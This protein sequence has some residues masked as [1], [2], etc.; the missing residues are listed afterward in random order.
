MAVRT[1]SIAFG[2]KRKE[3]SIIDGERA[4]T[5]LGRDEALCM[6]ASII[7]GA[8]I[9]PYRWM[10]LLDSQLESLELRDDE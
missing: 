6:I 5:R 3:F 8:D 10:S 7:L 2:T 9:P 4:C 1:V